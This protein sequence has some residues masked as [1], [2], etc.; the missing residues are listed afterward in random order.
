MFRRRLKGLVNLRCRPLSLG[1]I[2]R[3]TILLDPSPPL[4]PGLVLLAQK[5]DNGSK[6]L[7]LWQFICLDAL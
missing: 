7:Q 4:V 5:A 6:F 1:P 2:R 3:P